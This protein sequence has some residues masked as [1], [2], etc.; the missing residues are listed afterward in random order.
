MDFS[1]DQFTRAAAIHSDAIVFDAHYDR[2]YATLDQ[3][4]ADLPTL[5]AGGVTVHIRQQSDDCG[6]FQFFERSQQAAEKWPAEM[7][8][9]S[10]AADIRRAKADGCVASI[11]SIE[12]AGPLQGDITLLQLLYRLGLRNLGITWNTRNEAADGVLEARSAGG[13]TRFGVALVEEAQRLGIMLDISHLAPAGVRDLFAIYGG[14]VMATHSNARALCGHCRNLSD[15]Q[16]EMVARSG[17]VVGVTLVP[18]FIAD[19]PQD[20]TLDGLIDHVDH[21]VSVAGI[22]HVGIGTDWEGFSVP[23]NY[24]FTDISDFPAITEKLVQR[25]YVAGDIHQILGGNFLR[26][27][28]QVLG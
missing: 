19:R 26:V 24:F 8:I 5:R 12:G 27:I 6:I 2:L 20:A 13:L 4:H 18:E 15:E 14:P 25:G 1:N 17:G 21:I 23:A 16:I 7:H 28:E 3:A 11:L 9:V 10:C 22:D